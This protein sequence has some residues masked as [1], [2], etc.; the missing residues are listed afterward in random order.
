MLRPSLAFTP[1]DL[2]EISVIIVQCLAD[3]PQ[4]LY[5]CARV[6]LA[7][8]K[9]F[10]PQ[11]W[12]SIRFD[13]HLCLHLTPPIFQRYEHLIQELFIHD[14][15]FYDLYGP[16]CVNVKRIE[17]RPH[18]GSMSKCYPLEDDE[19]LTSVNGQE[20]VMSNRARHNLSTKV[21][22]RT[23]FLC[24]IHQ[25][26]ALH[27]L[28]EDWIEFPLTLSTQFSLLH[29]LQLSRPTLVSLYIS[30][31]VTTVPMLNLLIRQSP[32]LQSLSLRL[33]RIVDHFQDMYIPVGSDLRPVTLH[34]ACSMLDFQHVK[35]LRLQEVLLDIQEATISGACVESI[36]VVSTR[37]HAMRELSSP[38]HSE[39]TVFNWKLPRVQSL[40]YSCSGIR[41]HMTDG[42]PIHNILLSAC[43]SEDPS[44]GS[45]DST[46][47]PKSDAFRFKTLML[48]HTTI[49]RSAIHTVV[50]QLGYGLEVLE[51]TYCSG[52]RHQDIQHILAHCVHLR[53]FRGPEGGFL[54]THMFTNDGTLPFW[55]S[56]KLQELELRT[57]IMD[58]S[59]DAAL[60]EL[61]DI[62]PNPIPLERQVKGVLEQLSRQ[63]SL[64]T[65]DLSGDPNDWLSEDH[66]MMG[67]P[68][69]LSTG[70][71]ML[72][73]LRCMKRVVVTTH[74]ESMGFAEARWMKIHWPKLE[75]IRT[76]H[77]AKSEGWKCFQKE[78]GRPAM[79]L[80]W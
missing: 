58:Y 46:G 1:F 34:Q 63:K 48:C 56:T 7:W 32:H 47:N 18:M 22:A 43:S 60:D 57:L 9:I 45:G 28:H 3:D 73:D 51:L 16:A 10:I 15:R 59:R 61:P 74:E 54:A 17:Y 67:I 31:W 35:T 6:C 13:G 55:A 53:I 2:P 52:I 64:E 14:S 69:L 49:P 26:V 78:L 39:G 4:T 24:L 25:Q 79:P 66:F 36:Q 19:E 30:R 23:K 29:T 21:S 5:A 68:L 44:Q 42:H 50:T 75:T 62:I 37:H 11:L 27:D 76:K 65:L 33:V 38:Q 20:C 80:L 70:L 72:R 40:G 41:G 12:L 77:G 71:E 8:S